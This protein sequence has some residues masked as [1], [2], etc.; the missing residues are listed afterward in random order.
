M[1]KKF[2]VAIYSGEVPSTTF[3][4]RLIIG[5]SKSGCEVYLFGNSNKKITYKYPDIHIITYSSSKIQK[6]FQLVKFSI[7]L[8][9]FKN[10]SKRQL[11]TWMNSRSQKSKLNKLK[12]YPVLWHKPDIFHIQWAK[13][14]E[15]WMWVKDFDIKI[16]LSLLGTHINYSPITNSHWA[17]SYKNFFPKVDGFHAV[18][19]AIEKEAQKYGASPDK[20]QVVYSGLDPI[21]IPVGKSE[22]L[23]FKM[24]AMGRKHWVKGYHYAL[25]SC[26]ILKN[27]GIDFE[28]QI[29]GAADSEELQYLLMELGLE[30]E[31]ELLGKRP[32]VEVQQKIQAADLLLLSSVEEG[33]ANVVLEAMQLG[34][35]VLS[36]DCGGMSEVIQDGV[37]GFVVP[38]RNPEAMAAAIQKI[39][40]LSAEE[41]EKMIAAA[42]ETI[43]NRHTAS[44]MAEGMLELYHNVMEYK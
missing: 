29:I 11:D 13:S 9:L 26:L 39:Q 5:V 7:L 32:F 36:T 42:K 41:K 31:V 38:I 2:K 19:N 10:K 33:I 8:F 43:E 3:I 12:Y 37:N 44:K 28:F 25:E 24:I 14:L 21:E 27:A 18:S 30:K 4:E 16:V 23:R 35:L 1:K 17:V 22:N 6:L 20:T 40:G 15:D 34:T